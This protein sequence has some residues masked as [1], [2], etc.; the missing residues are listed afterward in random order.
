MTDEAENRYLILE[1]PPSLYPPFSATII[2]P[3]TSNKT[4]PKVCTQPTDNRPSPGVT[5]HSNLHPL[6]V[7]L[8]ARRGLSWLMATA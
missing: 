5:M 7:D 8:S 1:K 6:K 3:S 2:P 4:S